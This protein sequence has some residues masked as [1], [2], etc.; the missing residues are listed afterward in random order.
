MQLGQQ[1]S[2]NASKLETKNPLDMT[3]EELTDELHRRINE[4]LEA[5]DKQEPVQQMVVEQ[6]EGD[7]QVE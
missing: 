2:T 4:F 7:M 5:L 3:E 6:M 1:Q